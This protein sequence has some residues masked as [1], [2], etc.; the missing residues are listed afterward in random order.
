MRLL[1]IPPPHTHTHTH[2]HRIP[3]CPP[4]LSSSLSPP[5]A[6]TSPSVPR[7]AAGVPRERSCLFLHTVQYTAILSP[8]R[9]RH[10]RPRHRHTNAL[11]FLLRLLRVPCL[12][13]RP[14]PIQTNHTLWF[15]SIYPP[16]HRH[17]GF[18]RAHA[19]RFRALR[20]FTSKQ[21]KRRS[22]SYRFT[23]HQDSRTSPTLFGEDFWS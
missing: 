2:A 20:L 5:C 11:F 3:K 19:R 12:P 9:R 15:Y 4:R 17:V 23:V 21:K 8:P 6:P 13:T 22:A 10:R 16:P 7:Y 18:C 14:P 1:V